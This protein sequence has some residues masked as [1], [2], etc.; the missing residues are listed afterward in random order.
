[1]IHKQFD[2]ISKSDI[3][4]LIYNGV[5]ER[6]TIEYKEQLSGNS[7]G[8]KKEFLAD[9][10]S[11]ANASG[12]DI[13]YGIQEKRDSNGKTT[14]IPEAAK[15]LNGI[16][17]DEVVRKLE[18]MIRDGI[19]PRI[20]GL[21]TKVIDGFEDGSVILIRIPKS[22]NSPHM[23]TFKNHS[24][25][26]S[27]NSA[28]KYPLDV[29]EIRSAFITSESLAE[30]I[31]EFRVERIANIIADE[32]PIPLESNPK[33]VLHVIPI[34]SFTSGISVD[35]NVARNENN[36]LSL[37]PINSSSSSGWSQRYNFDGIV[38]F[39]T[40]IQTPTSYSYTQLFRNGA[41]EAVDAYHLQESKG[42]KTIHSIY[43]EEE[44]INSLQDYLQLQQQ[45]EL[46]PPVLIMLS[47]LGV[48]DYVMRVGDGLDHT[49][50]TYPIDRDNLII[51]E[52]V[53]ED[54]AMKASE[55]LRPA[56]DAIWQACGWDCC[57]NYDADGNW[58]G[59][60]R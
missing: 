41:I 6:K 36:L 7:D 33:I 56:F 15:G 27:R 50:H 45:I 29:N 5:T 14:G 20:I 30:R 55:I 4:S 60:K 21:Q 18:S 47:L 53:V 25:F 11:F 26:Y 54:Y 23:V 39:L 58:I 44:L 48:R 8:D 2:L 51:P 16:N 35:V 31:R 22:W 57:K 38:K 10:S 52:I 46:N 37:N 1:M 43:Y 13:I 3:E 32:T 24:R 19:A 9:I 17:S 42:G 34:A 49:R 28:G 59:N 12:G 40:G